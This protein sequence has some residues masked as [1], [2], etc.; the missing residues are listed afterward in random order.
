MQKYTLNS[1]LKEANEA[2]SPEEL[3]HFRYLAVELLRKEEVNMSRSGEK[4]LQM[5]QQDQDSINTKHRKVL[6]II[7]LSMCIAI[8]LYLYS[9]WTSKEKKQKAKPKKLEKEELLVDTGA[10]LVTLHAEKVK[11]VE[12]K[13]LPPNL[14]KEEEEKP[15]LSPDTE[16]HILD[17]L[18]EFERSRDF[19]KKD[20]RLT[21]LSVKIGVNHRYLSH[22]INTHK[23]TD[24]ASYINTLRI[25][26]IKD[27]LDTHPEALQYKISYLAEL[28]GFASH[29]RF[30]ITFKRI[31]GMSPSD[32]MQGL[33]EKLGVS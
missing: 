13:K 18:K 1:L 10:G 20:L 30:T 28:S 7:A 5:I 16:V 17:R 33:K 24:F 2:L 6:K 15:Y 4:I 3:A 27:Y 25:N 12:P 11:E 8:G 22:V 26:Y 19:L 29:S 21:T 23:Q 31:V 9:S 32:Y 14:P